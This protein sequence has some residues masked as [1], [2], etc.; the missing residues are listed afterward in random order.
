M[1]GTGGSQGVWGAV[2]LIPSSLEDCIFNAT[3]VI[4]HSYYSTTCYFTR[5]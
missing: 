1:E 2:G 4:P 5:I 3:F